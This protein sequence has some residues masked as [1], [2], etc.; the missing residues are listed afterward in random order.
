M[1]YFIIISFSNVIIL[2]SQ[3]PCGKSGIPDYCFLISSTNKSLSSNSSNNYFIPG[4]EVEYSCKSNNLK[5]IGDQ[6]RQCFVSELWSPKVPQ[7]LQPLDIK[8]VL[9]CTHQCSYSNLK[10][11]IDGDLKTCYRS[12]HYNNWWRIS[13][14]DNIPIKSIR[15][16]FSSNYNNSDYTLWIRS[17]GKGQ[18]F[19]LSHQFIDCKNRI[20]INIHKSFGIIAGNSLRIDS[21]FEFIL[22]EV[23]IFY[24]NNKN[25]FECGIPDAP[26]N[27]IAKTEFKNNRLFVYFEC[28]ESYRLEGENKLICN[29][30]GLLTNAFPICSIKSENENLSKNP[31]NATKF[32]EILTTTSTTKHSIKPY[33]CKTLE[34]KNGNFTFTNISNFGSRATLQCNKGFKVSSKYRT[35]DCLR[36]GS[37]SHFGSY[38]F[39]CDPI[40]CPFISDIPNGKIRDSSKFIEGKAFY[41]SE[42]E[43]HCKNSKLEL[44]YCGQSESW[45]QESDIENPEAISDLQNIC[46]TSPKQNMTLTNNNNNS[47]KSLDIKSLVMVCVIVSITTTVIIFV[48]LGFALLL[49]RKFS[50]PQSSNADNNETAM[51]KVNDFASVAFSSR[52]RT[53]T[54]HTYSEPFCTET[55]GY[56]ISEESN[57][58]NIYSQPYILIE[59]DIYS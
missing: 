21:N 5:L 11:T 33:T 3:K 42:I 37:W 17:D 18:M 47:L 25:E 39:S 55:N 38:N 10:K 34:D 59:N 20:L 12:K 24:L 2:K 44:R 16:S 27:G 23:K 26:L 9:N 30:T 8:S 58:E 7:C 15:L 45:V 54:I 49:K 41:L 6:K 51:P 28:I 22:C 46:K 1:L 4:T 36:N 14:K 48:L 53:A 43:I 40:Q 29:S 50:T 35:S 32:I 19:P 31:R 13:L 52:R 57:N 56:N